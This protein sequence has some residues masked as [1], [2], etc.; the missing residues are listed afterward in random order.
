MKKETLKTLLPYYIGQ[1]FVTSNSHG[2]I[3]VWTLAEINKYFDQYLDFKLILRKVDDITNDELRELLYMV[4][5]NDLRFEDKADSLKPSDIKFDVKEAS[6]QP[7][8]VL[9]DIY[10]GDKYLPDHFTICTVSGDVNFYEYFSQI[11]ESVA[12]EITDQA[13][14]VIWLLQRGFDLF[15][16]IDNEAAIDQ[17]TY[18]PPV[19]SI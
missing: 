17:A 10:V 8:I 4:I 6:D 12:Q 3:N 13:K 14:I 5:V 15:S 7:T 2:I 11:D 19:P 9:Q 18:S 1:G 16:M